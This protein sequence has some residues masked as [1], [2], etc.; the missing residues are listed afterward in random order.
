MAEFPTD[1][2]PSPKNWIKYIYIYKIFEN[3]KFTIKYS[4]FYQ[5]KK[6]QIY[7]KIFSKKNL[8]KINLY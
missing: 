5:R 1:R 2:A 8:F 4:Q 6:N 3:I 7:I